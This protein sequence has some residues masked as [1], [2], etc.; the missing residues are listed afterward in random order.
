MENS[1]FQTFFQARLRFFDAGA[2]S[3]TLS[4]FKITQGHSNRQNLNDVCRTGNDY[5]L[6]K[7]NKR[8]KKRIDGLLLLLCKYNLLNNDKV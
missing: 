6:I 1:K 5:T 4:R 2:A 8:K 7:L 3:S